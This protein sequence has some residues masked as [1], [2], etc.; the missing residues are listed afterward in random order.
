MLSRGILGIRGSRRVSREGLYY[1]GGCNIDVFYVS[2]MTTGYNMELWI[3]AFEH[4]LIFG[5]EGIAFLH[6]D[7]VTLSGESAVE[8]CQLYNAIWYE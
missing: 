3:F 7:F 5:I 8:G 4:T 6:F 2:T 1:H